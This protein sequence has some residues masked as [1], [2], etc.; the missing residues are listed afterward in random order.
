LS[1]GEQVAAMNAP[2]GMSPMTTPTGTG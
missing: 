1:T 2:S